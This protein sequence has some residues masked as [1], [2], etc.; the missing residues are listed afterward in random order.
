MR[1]TVFT[2]LACAE[3]ETVW[4]S[5]LSPAISG[6]FAPPLLVSTFGCSPP[7]VVV[8][9]LLAPKSISPADCCASSP[10]SSVPTSVFSTYCGIVPPP[11]EPVAITKSPFE[12]SAATLN[13]MV[14]AIELR[15]RL[16]GCT[17]FA[18]SAPLLSVGEAE[19]SVNWL[20]S[21]KPCVMW[22]EPMLDSTVVVALSTLPS[23]STIVNWLVPCSIRVV[24]TPSGIAPRSPGCAVPMLLVV[25]IRAARCF[26]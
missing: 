19:K 15:G 2:P 18:T 4:P 22:N 5:A 8:G 26:R 9:L 11:G 12:P 16:P 1:S 10:Q 25:L 24:S 20:L 17:R 3:V 14:G 23:P 13:T 21:R 6:S 7:I